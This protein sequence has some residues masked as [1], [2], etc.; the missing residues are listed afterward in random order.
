MT[1]LVLHHKRSGMT[2]D[3]TEYIGRPG[4]L[5]NPYT[6]LEKDT[7]A[8]FKVDTVEDAILNYRVYFYTQLNT[9]PV[10]RNEVA[11]LVRIYQHRGFLNLSCWCKD[12]LKPSKK[13]HGCH[14]DV[15]REFI[16]TTVPVLYFYQRTANTFQG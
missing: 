1:I 7:Q 13:D 14:C 16:L 9:N 11:R 2:A 6:H 10:F 12:E 5:G 8:Q 15:V 4:V 3:G